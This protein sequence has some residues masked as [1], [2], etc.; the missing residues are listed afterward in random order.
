MTGPR[1]RHVAPTVTN[2]RVGEEGRWR[3]GRAALRLVGR[4]R[5]APGGR[6]PAAPP[7]AIGRRGG[8][9]GV[10]ATFPP[11]PPLLP[12]RR[13]GAV[14]RRRQAGAARAFPALGG[15]AGTPLRA[16]LPHT[17]HGGTAV[18]PALLA[19]PGAAPLSN[20][21]LPGLVPAPHFTPSP[22]SASRRESAECGTALALPTRPALRPLSLHAP[23]CGAPSAASI[24]APRGEEALK[25]PLGGT[26]C[27]TDRG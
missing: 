24:I 14:L 23:T 9:V 22:G 21:R 16:P 20:P 13:L 4:A 7:P 12:P 25:Y 11:A 8:A 3:G 2:R 17:R 19:A 6:V 1:R 27:V 10:A 15:A 5:R 18:T 26:A